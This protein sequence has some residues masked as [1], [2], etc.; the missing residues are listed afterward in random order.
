MATTQADPEKGLE[1]PA[2]DVI[3][4]NVSSIHIGDI[5]DLKSAKRE[6]VDMAN[7]VLM[8]S[9]CTA[10]EVAAVD[11]K[12]LLRKI[13]IRLLPIVSATCSSQKL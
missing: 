12:K 5:A 1:T 11:Q 7:E 9:D 10:E 8:Q 13:D 3:Q 2:M 6:D 4:T